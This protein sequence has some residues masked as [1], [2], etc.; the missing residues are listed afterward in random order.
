LLRCA[1][2][3]STRLFVLQELDAQIESLR[4]ELRLA[5]TLSDGHNAHLDDSTAAARRQSET[6]QETLAAREARR[7]E[8]AQGVPQALLRQ[9]DRLRAHHKT[10]PWVVVL[11]GHC[12]VACNL[13]LPSAL[14][15]QVRRTREP[16]TCPNCHRLLV[17]R[18]DA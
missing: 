14:L 8:T 2:V 1:G 3:P 16:V 15:S 11:N 18:E 17:W 4:D 13:M 9:Y 5:H 7:A 6:I 12:C 10:R